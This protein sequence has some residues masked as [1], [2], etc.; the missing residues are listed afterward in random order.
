MGSVGPSV[1]IFQSK[2]LSVSYPCK[3]L[4]YYLYSKLFL[5]EN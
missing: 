1:K 3:G 4:Q 5:W 2:I